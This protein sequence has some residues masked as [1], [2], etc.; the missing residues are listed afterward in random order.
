MA[1]ALARDDHNRGYTWLSKL[2]VKILRHTA[3]KDGTYITS[4]GDVIIEDLMHNWRIKEKIGKERQ[5]MN[6]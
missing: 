4:G 6:A 2:L 5:K 1:E 3:V